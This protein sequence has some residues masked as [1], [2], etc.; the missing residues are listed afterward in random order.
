MK[1]GLVALAVA[2]ALSFA[3][4]PVFAQSAKPRVLLETSMGNITVELEP[5]RT[6]KTVANF[7][8]HVRD[9]GYDGTIFHRVIEGFMIQ[10]GGFRPDYSRAKPRPPVENE[11]DTGLSNKRGTIS[12]ARTSDPHS[13]TNQFFINSADNPPL[14]HQNKSVRGW[15]YTAF[16]RVVEGLPVVLRISRVATG[17]GGPFAQDAPR[18]QVVLRKATIVNE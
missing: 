5:E 6:P 17:R 9:G 4:S 7:L 2:V 15:G 3:V 8:A 12:M 14:D 10:G 11:A 13:A 18:E 16:G 1:R